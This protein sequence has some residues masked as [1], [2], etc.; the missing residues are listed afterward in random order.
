MFSWSNLTKL[1]SK[2]C[3]LFL[4]K[5]SKLLFYQAAT[6]LVVQKVQIRFFAEIKIML[7]V[8]L[9]VCTFVLL[10]KAFSVK[11]L[12][13]PKLIQLF[14]SLKIT[15]CCCHTM[16][17]WYK[18]TVFIQSSRQYLECSLSGAL[19]GSIILP[20]NYS[21]WPISIV[22]DSVVSWLKHF[23]TRPIPKCQTLL[24]YYFINCTPI[25]DCRLPESISL[26][27]WIGFHKLS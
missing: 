26:K 3:Y 19:T 11:T 15:C 17:F 13:H 4:R 8:L 5:N 7:I 14:A 20:Q 25:S 16:L 6:T 18:L 2:S 24:E 22:N 23:L 21:T 12:D 1:D 10:S 9:T 27:L